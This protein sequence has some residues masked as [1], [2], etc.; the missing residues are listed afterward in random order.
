MGLTALDA[1]YT[2]IEA[3]SEL[4]FLVERRGN[5]EDAELR[6]VFRPVCDGRGHWDQTPGFSIEFV[7]KRR[8]LLDCRLPTWS[9]H[10]LAVTYIVPNSSTGHSR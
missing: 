5:I 2:E 4:H 9:V 10:R 6:L 8:I 7:D 1:G 3:E